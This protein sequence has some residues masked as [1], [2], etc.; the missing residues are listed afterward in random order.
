MTM[1]TDAAERV[2][3]AAQ[4]AHEEALDA[5][6]LPA[7]TDADHEAKQS[8]RRAELRV[9]AEVLATIYPLALANVET[10]DAIRQAAR[11]ALIER[12]K[13]ADECITSPKIDFWCAHGMHLVL[14][15]ADW[16]VLP[17]FDVRHNE[18]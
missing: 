17:A 10:F 1:M 16:G 9:H 11:F 5:A 12:V 4:R 6:R 15:L 18:A 7:T 8:A 13:K 2:L 14:A 3:T